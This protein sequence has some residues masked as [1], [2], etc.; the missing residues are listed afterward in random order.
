MSWLWSLFCILGQS[1]ILL[2]QFLSLLTLYNC[3]CAVYKQHKSS[4][5]KFPSQIIKPPIFEEKSYQTPSLLSPPP[6]L[7]PYSDCNTSCGL[8]WYGLF[9]YWKSEFVLNF[10][11]MTPNFM[12]LN[13][14]T[15]ISISDTSCPSP[16]QDS[17]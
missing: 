2:S 16:K 4:N 5:I 15:Q 8:I 17:G 14:S 1:D 6:T 7:C 3:R 13:F 10:G 12:C 9:M 11:C